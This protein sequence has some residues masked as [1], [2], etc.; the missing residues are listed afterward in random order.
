MSIKVIDVSS[1]PSIGTRPTVG[2]RRHVNSQSGNGSAAGNHTGTTP[3]STLDSSAATRVR[4]TI[5]EPKRFTPYSDPTPGK[6]KVHLK[7]LN[8][9]LIKEYDPERIQNPSETPRSEIK[10]NGVRPKILRQARLIAKEIIVE[11]KKAHA[12][13]AEYRRTR[14]AYNTEL[15]DSFRYKIEAP[16]ADGK[17]DG[18]RKTK[19]RYRS[20]EAKT[21]IRERL[22]ELK[23][24]S[25]LHPFCNLYGKNTTVS[26]DSFTQVFYEKTNGLI[27]DGKVERDLLDDA[28]FKSLVAFLCTRKNKKNGFTALP[29]GFF[30]HADPELHKKIE[31]LG[32]Y[33][34]VNVSGVDTVE[35]AE[36][37]KNWSGNFSKNGLQLLNKI[38]SGDELL[39][40]LFPGYPIRSWHVYG[41]NKWQGEG[42]NEQ[43]VKGILSQACKEAFL[44][45]EGVVNEDLTINLDRVAEVDWGKVFWDK[46]YGLRGAIGQCQ[47]FASALDGL[48][49][50]V[51]GIIGNKPGQIPRAKFKYPNKW[52]EGNAL[53]LIDEL[54]RYIVEDKLALFDEQCRVSTTKI[55]E[56][57]DWGTQYNDECAGCLR[58]AGVGT[59]YEA[60]KRVYPALFG[61]GE[62]Q[63]EPGSIRFNGMWKGE[64]GIKLFKL[65]FAKSIHSV[66]EQLKEA[67]VEAF[68]DHEVKF[69][70]NLANPL[71]ITRSDFINLKNYY[72]IKKISW[73]D[74][75]LAFGLTAGYM[76]IAGGTENAFEILLGK[77]NGKTS[78]FGKTDIPIDDVVE[79]TPMRTQLISDLLKDLGQL[80]TPTRVS[81]NGIYY[82]TTG[83]TKGDKGIKGIIHL[84][85]T[86][87]SGALEYRPPSDVSEITSALYE[88]FAASIIPS[89]TKD[90]SGSGLD[91]STAL[92]KI[93]IA[94]YPAGINEGKFILSDR[95]LSHLLKFLRDIV[96]DD[97]NIDDE[98]KAYLKNLIDRV[99]HLK[100]PH[101]SPRDLLIAAAETGKSNPIKNNAFNTLNQILEHLNEL[102]A[103]HEMC[104]LRLNNS[105]T[106]YYEN[107][108]SQIAC[109]DADNEEPL[110][111][112]EEEVDETESTAEVEETDETEVSKLDD[113]ED[114]Y[115]DLFSGEIAEFL[116]ETAR[117]CTGAL[118]PSGDAKTKEDGIIE[119]LKYVAK[120]KTH[121]RKHATEFLHMAE[122]GNLSVLIRMLIQIEERSRSRSS[123]RFDYPSL[124]AKALPAMHIDSIAVDPALLED[125][126]TES[127]EVNEPKEDSPRIVNLENVDKEL[128]SLM[129]EWWPM[130]EKTRK[131]PLALP[132][133]YWNN[134]VYVGV[135]EGFNPS[136]LKDLSDKLKCRVE[137]RIIKPESWKELLNFYTA[138]VKPSGNLE[139][140][141]LRTFISKEE[142]TLIIQNVASLRLAALRYAEQK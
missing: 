106:V 39:K 119:T 81:V 67:G 43:E 55:K 21:A 46:Q 83:N 93:L 109:E 27:A 61:W 114:D 40:Y 12:I 96:I 45:Q 71:H 17:V 48:E 4:I 111:E 70:P 142:E 11:W 133:L 22:A 112:V 99:R 108:F 129:P 52:T 113:D 102:V 94:K 53:G 9:T 13:K 29:F 35:K 82:K 68:E 33:F 10:L 79:R 130:S 65:R 116:D 140:A 105:N 137:H 57:P 128:F 107:I 86:C 63:V 74:H 85:K 138:H 20:T 110:A 18:K 30:D 91:R 80:N 58:R 23:A 49:L 117:I 8:E 98:L 73:L 127:F 62:E 104:Y 84:E 95:R 60:L 132:L 100:K 124:R 5:S 69:Y 72:I 115:T 97:V 7:G 34:V 88:A 38:I 134:V 42:I 64:E 36:Q 131:T 51:P 123:D 6:V 103:K 59:A 136:M 92:E 3:L 25:N 89:P 50:A 90:N 2:N 87:L 141:R 75:F 118:T 78:C 47:F 1:T 14:Q 66:F 120:D 44:D 32:R 24:Q 19:V 122:A 125:T 15:G 56:V 135:P 41:T 126:S 54:T 77:K 26:M 28:G 121:M 139:R 101:D 16:E 76:D 31:M 37:F